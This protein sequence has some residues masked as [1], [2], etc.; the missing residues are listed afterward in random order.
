MLRFL[1]CLHRNFRLNLFNL[2]SMTI[3]L[4]V[5]FLLFWWQ[6]IYLIKESSTFD[7]INTHQCV[8]IASLNFVQWLSNICIVLSVTNRPSQRHT[9]TTTEERENGAHYKNNHNRRF[10]YQ[11]R[12]ISHDWNLSFFSLI[13]TNP[14]TVHSHSYVF[15]MI[16]FL[17]LSIRLQICWF[18]LFRWSICSLHIMDYG[19]LLNMYIEKRFRLNFVIISYH[20]PF[21][22][23]FHITRQFNF[24]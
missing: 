20:L 13:L 24:F 21:S 7:L 8:D 3:F 10:H 2:K 1:I 18:S 16:C 6:Q 14:K 22:Y 4:C 5:D 17:F 9:E 15:R 11:I 12:Y 23:L 19:R